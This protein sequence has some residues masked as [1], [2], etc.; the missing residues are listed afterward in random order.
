M[1]FLIFVLVSLA[2]AAF[3]M[4]R[5]LNENLLFYFTPSD[6][7]AGKAPLNH[8]FR[9]GGMV[10]NGSIKR[11]GLTVQFR[12]TDLHQKITVI[13]T[14]LLPDLFREGQGVIVHG[15]TDKTGVFTAEEVLAK[16]DEK[17]TP[18]D[19]AHTLRDQ[20]RLQQDHP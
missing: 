16:H 14:G 2:I 8:L 17:Y 1:S 18:P 6:I 13:Y 20:Q 9:A 5:A 3:F 7:V 4:L 19:V 12:I 11:S 10:E 15:K